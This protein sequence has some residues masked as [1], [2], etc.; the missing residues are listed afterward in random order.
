M[1]YAA[2]LIISSACDL[3]LIVAVGKDPLATSATADSRPWPCALPRA[4][5]QRMQITPASRVVH[6]GYVNMDGGNGGSAW[7]AMSCGRDALLTGRL[8]FLPHDR[9]FQNLA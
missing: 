3:A 2:L 7:T 8:L 6:D 1:H 5:V 4:D 9:N